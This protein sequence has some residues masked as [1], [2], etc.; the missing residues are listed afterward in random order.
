NLINRSEFEA[1][2]RRI[3]YDNLNGK[4]HSEWITK[5][6]DAIYNRVAALIQAIG[7]IERVWAKMPNQYIVMNREVWNLFAVFCTRP[8]FQD[9]L[10]ARM[11]IVSSNLQSIFEQ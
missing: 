8:Q 9:V 1:S 5:D 10:E 4:Y 7:R 2:L 3:R 11:P 6:S